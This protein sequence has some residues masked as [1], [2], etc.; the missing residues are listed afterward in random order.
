[1]KKNL[2]ITSEL[3]EELKKAFGQL[4]GEDLKKSEFERGVLY[5][6]IQVLQKIQQWKEAQNGR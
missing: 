2:H 6:T 1:M 3:M 5:G 4:V